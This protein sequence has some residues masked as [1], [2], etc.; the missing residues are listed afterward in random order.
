[1]KIV[2][3]APFDEAVPPKKYGGT[4]LVIYNITEE[5]LKRGHKVYLLASGDSKTSAKLLPIFPKALRANAQAKDPRI[6]DSLKFI[7]ISRILEYLKNLDI[8]IIHNH[9]GWR[10]LPFSSFIKPPIITTLH[11]PLDVENQSLFYGNFKKANYVSISN[12]Q[13]EPL[14]DL[15][16]IA[17]IYNGIALKKFPFSE[18]GGEYLAFLG[19]ISP[20]KGPVQAIEAAKKAGLKLKMAAKV[21]LVDK[22][23]FEKEVAPLIDQ[24]QIIFLGEIDHKGK[25]E[26]L[27]GAKALL[28]PIQWREPFGLF[29]I[30]AMACGTPV[31]AFDRGSA[32][33][34]IEDKK[35]GFIVKNVKE[36]VQ[37]IKNINKIDRR[38]CRQQVEK[39]FT[40]E[41]M[42]DG[43]EKV[44]YKILEKKK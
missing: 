32:R 29:F 36:I 21:D 11:G 33:E 28:C 7:G 17:T 9:I 41:K 1:M 12:N 43:Y 37:A 22:A 14:P 27:K 18:E 30:E 10:L 2:Q 40:V 35:T 24:K 34:I 8:D 31:I 44:Y 4:E 23:F 19:R 20:E 6:K 39:Y 5:L 13:R 42:T 38:K 25:V 3:I 15:N 16:Y 26:L